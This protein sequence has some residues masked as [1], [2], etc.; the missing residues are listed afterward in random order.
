MDTY[1]SNIR[2]SGHN[3]ASAS[4]Y[5]KQRIEIICRTFLS[6]IALTLTHFMYARQSFPGYQ[7]FPLGS[8]PFL[9]TQIS[10]GS[11]PKGIIAAVSAESI[12]YCNWFQLVPHEIKLEDLE[13]HG[14]WFPG[15][16]FPSMSSLLN[17]VVRHNATYMWL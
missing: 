16:T 5:V 17:T 1:V 10:P 4:H 7:N 12:S 14:V 6:T 2:S 9:P 11:S 8:G 3:H 15:R 13:T